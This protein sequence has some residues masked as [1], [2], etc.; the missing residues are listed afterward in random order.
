MPWSFDAQRLRLHTFFSLTCRNPCPCSVT[1]RSATL[2]SVELA[3]AVWISLGR[4]F[5]WQNTLHWARRIPGFPHETCEASVGKQ[6]IPADTERRRQRPA[7]SRG[8]ERLCRRARFVTIDQRRGKRRIEKQCG[9][10]E[11]V[12]PM[13][14]TWSTVMRQSLFMLITVNEHIAN[15]ARMQRRR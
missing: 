8:W 7:A 11:R 6:T 3:D 1:M 10:L 12:R 9:R 15:A 4:R 13:K 2:P 5:Q 14:G